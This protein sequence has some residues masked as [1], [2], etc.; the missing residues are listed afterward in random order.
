MVPTNLH[1]LDLYGTDPSMFELNGQHLKTYCGKDMLDHL[2]AGAE[3]GM[4]RVSLDGDL[5]AA[6]ADNRLALVEGRVDLVRQDLA[7]NGHRLDIVA[8]RAAED[9]EA[10]QNEKYVIFSNYYFLC[11]AVVSF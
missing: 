5:R 7:K 3:A 8:A 1:L 2:I 11:V 4:V 6:E 10:A 9:S